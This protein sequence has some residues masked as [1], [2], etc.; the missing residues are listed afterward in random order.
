[1]QFKL[2]YSRYTIDY[3]TKMTSASTGMRY[4]ILI[5]WLLGSHKP[6]NTTGYCCS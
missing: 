6:P 3:K 5:Y 4:L 1:M 2:S